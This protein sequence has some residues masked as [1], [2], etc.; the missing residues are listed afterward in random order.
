MDDGDTI[1]PRRA[2]DILDH[3]LANPHVTDTFEGIA[4]WRLM[5]ELVQL[6]VEETETALRWLVTNGYL[7]KSTGAAA[8]P[9]YRLNATKRSEAEQLMRVL[10]KP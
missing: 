8:P 6:R 2:T 5:E 1:P 7:E 3:Y 4:G 9:L 10:K